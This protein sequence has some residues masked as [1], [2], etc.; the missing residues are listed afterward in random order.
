MKKQQ[1]DFLFVRT[2][3]AQRKLEVIHEVYLQ[4]LYVYGA[5]DYIE[6]RFCFL[7]LLQE[8]QTVIFTA[9]PDCFLSA[10]HH[11][12]ILRDYISECDNKI[13][14]QKGNHHAAD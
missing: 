5:G 12:E 8:L 10:S 11:F 13:L 6:A 14:Q 3:Y 4:A 9:A 2:E 1:P 7:F